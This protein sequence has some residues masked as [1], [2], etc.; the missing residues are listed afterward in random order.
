[1][2]KININYKELLI[3][4][5]LSIFLTYFAI[6]VLKINNNFYHIKGT[7]VFSKDEL[8]IF[9]STYY[10][11]HSLRNEHYFASKLNK[12]LNIENSC[13]RNRNE[14]SKPIEIFGG[15][16]SLEFNIYLLDKKKTENCSKIIKNF[17]KQISKE[18]MQEI[19]FFKEKKNNSQLNIISEKILTIVGENDLYTSKIKIL[20]YSSSK[21]LYLAIFF[22]FTFVI[23]IFR[24]FF[25]RIKF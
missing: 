17:L 6:I 4:T 7:V 18:I 16:T 5:T 21:L 9:N 13:G 12:E 14:M 15:P 22:I 24:I 1:M 20:E 3:Y 2:K 11:Y 23:F 19:I 10:P 8:G 25:R